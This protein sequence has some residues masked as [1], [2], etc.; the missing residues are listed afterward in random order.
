MTKQTR[1]KFLHDSIFTA[2]A[3]SA[4]PM[5]GSVNTA[6]AK[7]KNEKLLCAVIGC[8]GRGGQSH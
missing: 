7:S 5:I 2:A 1:R 3:I 4:A 6:Q 8:R